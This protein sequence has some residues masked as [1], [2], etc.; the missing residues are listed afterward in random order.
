MNRVTF[1][2]DWDDTIV[3]EYHDRGKTGVI[4]AHGFLSNRT[5]DRYQQLAEALQ[6]RGFSVLV[7][8]FAG[9][10]AS[11]DVRISVNSEAADLR[12]SIKYLRRQGCERIGVVG[13]SLGGLV[14]FRCHDLVDAIV[15]W[16]PVTAPLPDL[17]QEYQERFERQ[18][19]R[20][21]ATTDSGSY[22]ISPTFFREIKQIDTDR[23]LGPVTC[24]VLIVHGEHDETVPKQHSLAALSTLQEGELELLDTDHTFGSELDHAITVTVDWLSVQLDEK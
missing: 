22:A 2:N 16:A 7:P 21:I 14:A 4:V 9:S 3:A 18:D 17:L 13:H 10:G 19:D 5:D 11:D 24:P 8:D 23:L 6:E 20:F 15:G 12:A 1:E